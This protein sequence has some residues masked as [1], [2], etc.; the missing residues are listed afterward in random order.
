MS[1][2]AEIVFRNVT[3]RYT[4]RSRAAVHDLSLAL[5]SEIAMQLDH[6]LPRRNGFRAIDLDFIIILRREGESEQQRDKTGADT[7]R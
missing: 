7:P 3:K 1:A 4:G 2:A 5:N 6:G